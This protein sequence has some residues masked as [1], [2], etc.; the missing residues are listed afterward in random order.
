VLYFSLLKGAAF[1]ASI[2]FIA[3]AA[4]LRATGG[5]AGVGRAT[6]L[7]VVVATVVMMVWDLLLARLLRVFG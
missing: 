6:T 5:A 3:C 4:G 2:A 7:S 1:G